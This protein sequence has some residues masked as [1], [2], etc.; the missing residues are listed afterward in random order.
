[1]NNAT[2]HRLLH[3]CSTMSSDELYDTFNITIEEDGV[4]DEVENKLYRTLYEW[5][6]QMAL[7]D[8]TQSHSK[9]HSNREWVD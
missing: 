2:L 1:M 6:E 3:Q 8:D 9:M 5:A 4:W 7:C